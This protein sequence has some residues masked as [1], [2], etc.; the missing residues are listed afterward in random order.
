M[1]SREKTEAKEAQAPQ[2]ADVWPAAAMA[3]GDVELTG[4]ELGPD[5][6]SVPTVMVGEDEALVMMSRPGRVIFR[7]PEKAATGM[8]TVRTAAG[9]SNQAPLRVARQLASEL[10]PVTNPVVSRTGMIYAAISGARGKEVPVSVVRVSPGGRG[11]PF[12][13]GILNATG[14]AISPEDDLYVS[15]RAEGNVYRVEMGGDPELYVEGMGVATGM[16]FDAEGNLYVGDRSGTIFKI[17]PSKKI[18]VHATL[19]PSVSAYHMAVDAEGGLYVTAPTMSSNEAIWRVAPNGEVRVWY[20]GLGRAQG[21]ALA[22]D[23][24]LYVAACLHGERGLVHVTAGGK[25]EMALTAPNLV[26]V[27]FSQLG[28]TILATPEA[29][30]EVDLGVEALQIG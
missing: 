30:Y 19:E 6:K 22:S 25:A 7:V 28:T 13:S 9:V 12:V 23:G 18:F 24:S 16:V 1:L 10:N 27:A 3:G 4:T 20:R 11:V 15:S 5:A 8:V 2:I 26:G 21:L 14:L 29:V 17:N